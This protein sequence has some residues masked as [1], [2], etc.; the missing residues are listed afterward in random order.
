MLDTCMP[1][2]LDTLIQDEIT[3]IK[4]AWAEV[5]TKNRLAAISTLIQA[6]DDLVNFVET[7]FVSTAGAD[8]KAMV[9]SAIDTLY[10]DTLGAVLPLWLKPFSGLI[11]AAV[12]DG[13]SV[14][15]D[16]IVS[17]YNA[18]AWSKPAA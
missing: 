12:N 17:K 13:V 18:G 7:K 3:K 8:K 11:Q 9:M 6:V 5:Q 15:I 10:S 14:L 16:F 4:A 1:T 2:T